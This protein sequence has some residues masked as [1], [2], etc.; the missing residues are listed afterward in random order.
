MNKRQHHA[1]GIRL[2]ILIMWFDGKYSLTELL[3]DSANQFVCDS[4]TLFALRVRPTSA[5]Q[6]RRSH[7][8]SVNRLHTVLGPQRRDFTAATAGRT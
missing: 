1:A 4:F 6:P 2:W 7:F 3:A 8:G 5:A